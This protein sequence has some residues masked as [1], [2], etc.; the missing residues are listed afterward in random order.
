GQGSLHGTLHRNGTDVLVVTF[1]NGVPM[2]LRA[3]AA[4]QELATA[5][6]RQAPG[7]AVYDLRW[8]APLPAHDLLEQASRADRVLVVDETR[9]TGGVSE[10]VVATLVD[11]GYGGR[12]SRV[13]SKDSIIPLGPAA[14]TVLLSEAEIVDALLD[15]A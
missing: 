2:S 5:Q 6:G 1:G 8:L 11:G 7:A 14:A 9:R 4:A 10:G 3:V 12:I 13:T 15:G